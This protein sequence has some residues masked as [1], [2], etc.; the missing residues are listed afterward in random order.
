MELKL[1]S[2]RF[3][4]RATLM[5][6]T[7]DHPGN[8][9]LNAS[10]FD[11]LRALRTAGIRT[12]GDRLRD[13]VIRLIREECALRDNATKLTGKKARIKTLTEEREGLVKQMPQPASE[14]EAKLQRERRY[15][16]AESAR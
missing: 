12:E 15:A 6:R 5:A 9:G 13:D 1:P 10:S 16:L 3:A 8:L 2:L 14:E 4:Q 7:G 11:E